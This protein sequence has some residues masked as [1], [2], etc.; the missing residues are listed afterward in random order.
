M[1]PDDAQLYRD[2]IEAKLPVREA[3]AIMGLRLM[4]LA[5]ADVLPVYERAMAST[6][7]TNV[8]SLA[9]WRDCHKLT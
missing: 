8:V 6:N 5:T 1:Q 2:V 4:R 9:A 3:N 7:S